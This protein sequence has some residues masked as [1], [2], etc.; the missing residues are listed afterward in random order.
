MAQSGGCYLPSETSTV[1]GWTL[2][3]PVISGA[4]QT[5]TTLT[6]PTITTPTITTPAI[7]GAVSVTNSSTSASIATTRY[8]LSDLTLTPATTVASTGSI[9]AVRGNINL[10]AGKT[11][12]DGFFY[13]VQGKFTATTGTMNQT[14]A[15]RITGLLGQCDLGT[16]TITSGQVSCVWADLQ[17]SGPTFTSTEV[18]IIR[19]TNSSATTCNAMVFF[20]GQSTYLFTAARDGG[21]PTYFGATAPTSL[22]KSLKIDVAGTTYYI[23]LYT[24]AS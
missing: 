8:V 11:L 18:N 4:S 1:T 19:A 12:T 14:S 13:G 21:A 24:A 15:G 23:G 20:Y 17:G 9:A 6:S 10:S 5:S 7:T 16:M 3:N 2:I 22:A